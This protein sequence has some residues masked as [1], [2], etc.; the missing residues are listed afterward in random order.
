MLQVVYADEL[1][2][3][4]TVV[5]F[6]LL[7]TVRLFTGAETGTGRLVCASLAGGAYSLIL[8]APEMGWL[9]MLL[10]RTAMCVSLVFLA[11]RLR[12][13]RSMMRCTLL[14]LGVSFLYA[15]V[16]FWLSRVAGGFFT[17]RNG[18]GYF[19]PGLGL[20]LA[21]SVG[22]YYLIRWIRKTFFRFRSADMVYEMALTRDRTT[23]KTHALLDSGN[24]ARDPFF[25]RPVIIVTESVAARLTGVREPSRFGTEETR[26]ARFRLLPVSSVGEETLLPAFTADKA[27]L[28]RD[29][30]VR[31]VPSPCVAV[32]RDPL[33][34]E[35]YE[36]LIS[37]Y[38]LN[39]EE[40]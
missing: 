5:N 32:T 2:F 31:E 39:G 3:L 22:L 26:D 24:H 36:A 14:F 23:V 34:G 37:E 9:P 8:L 4:N 38:V 7:L 30:I 1:V 20:L 10:T 16:F 18:V 12:S 25:H 11:F 40:A 29:G 15:G 13:L 28:R 21:G 33:G 6:V 17:M 35:R 27:V 19:D